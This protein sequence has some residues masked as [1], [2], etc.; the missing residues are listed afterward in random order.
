MN[1]DVDAGRDDYRRRVDTIL[2][3]LAGEVQR[4]RLELAVARDDQLTHDELL[5]VLE[6]TP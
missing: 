1:A 2:F 6:A 3:P 4:M 5:A